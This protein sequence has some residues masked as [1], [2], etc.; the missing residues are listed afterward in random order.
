MNDPI[1]GVKNFIASVIEEQKGK[2]TLPVQVEVKHLGGTI[3]YKVSV[4]KDD[5]GNYRWSDQQLVGEGGSLPSPWRVRFIGSG[6]D[7]IPFER[8]FPG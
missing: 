5:Q 1:V 2:L 7:E 8:D 6:K 3:F 4:S